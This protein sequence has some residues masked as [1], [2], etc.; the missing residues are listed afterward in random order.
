MVWMDDVE[1]VLTHVRQPTI[2]KGSFTQKRARG[3]L[4]KHAGYEWNKVANTRADNNKGLQNGISGQTHVS[5][6]QPYY[7]G[8]AGSGPQKENLEY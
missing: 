5:K 4:D 2:R 1:R 6:Q 7:Y 3:F 8:A